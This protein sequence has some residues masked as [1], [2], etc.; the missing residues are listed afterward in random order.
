MNEMF[1]NAQ[2]PD[3]EETVAANILSKKFGVVFKLRYYDGD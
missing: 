1:E 2:R 3:D